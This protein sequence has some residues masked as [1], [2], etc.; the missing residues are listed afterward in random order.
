[1]MHEFRART[2]LLEKQLA[3]VNGLTVGAEMG[4]VKDENTS[5][6]ADAVVCFS[7]GNGRHPVLQGESRP[8]KVESLV[9]NV[10]G[11]GCMHFGVE[12]PKDTA[13][14][15]FQKWIGCCYK[16][17]WSCNPFW[18][19]TFD[20]FPDHPIT[21]GVTPFTIK[22][23]WYFNMRFS[24]GFTAEG[25]NEIDDVMT[26]NSHPCLLRPLLMKH[27]TAPTCTRKVPTLISK[28]RKDERKQSCGLS[29]VPAV[30]GDLDSLEVISTSTG[31]TTISARSS[32]TPFVG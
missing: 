1:M 26:S 19:A 31:K 11:F 24:D 18:D 22:G 21:W 10:T 2:I 8:E 29:N 3:E 7:D 27:A 14:S 25:P 12:V 17:Q 23:E 28:L 5:D 6:D 16:N 9:S 30:A 20:Q 15:Q 4:W 32:S 13:G